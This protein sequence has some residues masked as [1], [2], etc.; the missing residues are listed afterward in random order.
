MRKVKLDRVEHCGPLCWLESLQVLVDFR[1]KQDVVGHDA[2]ILRS[3]GAGLGPIIMSFTLVAL[4]HVVSMPDR[5]VALG[6]SNLTRGL[7]AV[8]SAARGQWGPDVE[9]FAALGLGRSYGER[10]RVLIR[11]LP[12]IL[13]SGLWAELDRRP[14]APTR[15]VISDVG[16]DIL[17]G[18]SPERIASWVEECVR[19]LEHHGA[20]I[21]ITDLPLASIRR[22][23]PSK[24]WAFRTFLWPQ[25]RLSHG[26]VLAR[27][28]AVVAALEA[29][30]TRHRLQFF[31]L[32]PEWYGFDPVHFRLPAWSPA[33]REI[34]VGSTD[35]TTAPAVGPAPTWL[36][37]LRLYT[38]PPERRWLAGIER[39]KSQAGV[40]LAGGGRLWLY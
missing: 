22:L 39:L 26:E 5:L 38:L 36:E 11:T 6:A 37:T 2:R 32:R 13:D 23:G 20:D 14:K 34:V 15:A 24:F 30:A 12:G 1:C 25:C 7:R 16:N 31:R 10:S 40:A 21:V 35:P 4:C 27:A 17:Y 8:V 33:W 19:R 29:I 18:S 3:S 28:E 9:V